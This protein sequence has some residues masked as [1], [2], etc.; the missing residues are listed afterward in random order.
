M[1]TCPNCSRF[2]L[3]IHTY[4]ERKLTSAFLHSSSIEILLANKNQSFLKHPI[5]LKSLEIGPSNLSVNQIIFRGLSAKSWADEN[6]Y[7]TLGVETDASAAKIRSAYIKLSKE[8]HPDYNIKDSKQETDKIHNKF[9]QINEAYSVLGNPRDRKSYDLQILMREDPRW[10]EREEVRTNSPHGFRS[11]PSSFEE[12]AR[13]MGFRPQD[14]D[15]YKKHGNYPNTVIKYIIAFVVVGMI[16]QYYAIMW[17]YTRHIETLNAEHNKNLALYEEAI[18][19][20]RKY[21]L[22]ENMDRI[23]LKKDVGPGS[24]QAHQG[25]PLTVD[26]EPKSSQE[27]EISND[28]I[29][30]KPIPKHST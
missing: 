15:Y 22:Q 7:T 16:F 17:T 3:K 25:Y 6:H 27:T 20:S 14:P 19:N 30:L 12:R 18:N 13:H 29:F 21:T 10:R 2:I 1:L 28:L 24:R 23:I 11:E 5:K 9:V 8:Y 26:A 4:A